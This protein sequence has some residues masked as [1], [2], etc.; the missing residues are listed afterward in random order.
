[1]SF[2][3]LSTFSSGNPLLRPT[4]SDAVQGNYTYKDAYVFTLK[5]S[6]DKNVIAGF[7]PHVD[8]ATNRIQYYAENIDHQQTLALTASLPWQVTPWWKSQTNLTG[9]WQSLATVYLDS[10]VSRTVWNAQL[11]SSQTFTLPRKFTAELT[12]FYYSPTVFGLYRGRSFG[13]VTVGLQKILPND[14]G[15]LRLTLSDIFWTN[16]G[17]YTST[18]PAL[19]I[20]TTIT[21]VGEPRVF[22]L[23]YSRSFG[24]KTVKSAKSR[25]TGSEEERSRLQSN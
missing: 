16:I 2:I 17:R 14:K 7:Q 3:D 5:Y 9:L 18:I 12:G 21:F 6:F 23:T 20:N 4:I 24:S 8:A 10:P 13:Q 25:A 1:M 11:N 15:T 22:R 19:N